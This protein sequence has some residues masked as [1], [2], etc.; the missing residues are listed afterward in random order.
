[1]KPS[2]RIDNSPHPLARAAWIRAA[3]QEADAIN[4]RYEFRRRFEL[5]EAIRARVV[6]TADSR[7]R[8]W[9]NGEWVSDGPARGYPGLSYYDTV[10]VELPAGNNTIEVEL[11]YWGVDTFQYLRASGGLIA[12]VLTDEGHQPLI[13]TDDMWMARPATQ[14]LRR[15]PRISCQQGFEEH[16]VAAARPAVWEPAVH[17]SACARELLPRETG[18]LG[19]RYRALENVVRREHVREISGGWSFSL[20]LMFSPFPRGI[21]LHGMA[22]AL[23]ARFTCDEA[24]QLRLYVLGN[25]AGVWV[26]G[27]VVTITSE[28]DLQRG[29]LELEAGS[30]RIGIALFAE[31]YQSTE[32]AVGWDGDGRIYWKP[33]GN[34]QSPWLTSGPLWA[35][36]RDT[37]C[38]IN[39]R[40]TSEDDV[41]FRAPFGG[42]FM[43]ADSALRD[44]SCRLAATDNDEIFRPLHN[45]ELHTADAYLA[46]RTDLC[47]EAADE[48]RET[49]CPGARLVYDLGEMTVGYLELEIEAEENA[50]VDIF[51][52]EHIQDGQIQYL[53]QNGSISYRNGLRYTASAGRQTFCSRQRRGFRYVL[54]VVRK[55]RI[56]LHRLGVHEATYQPP[57]TAAFACS[58][59]RLNR[60]YAVAQRTLLLCMEDTFTDCP[61]YEQAFWLGDAR[62]EALFARCAFGAADLIEHSLRLAARSLESLPMV[63]SQCPSGWDVIIPSFSFLW[64]IAVW[65]S[66]WES[67]YIGFLKELYP[68]L[69]LNLDNA[70]RHC[71]QQGLFRARAWNFFD[72]TGIDQEH[73]T[74]LHNSLLLAW[75]LEAGAKTA[76]KLGEDHDAERYWQQSAKL[77]QSIETLWDEDAGS[78]RDAI[79]P[80]GQPSPG[81]SQHTSFLALVQNLGPP[82]HRAAAVRN[83]LAPPDSLTQVGSPNA[84]FFL[85]ETLLREDF[86]QETLERLRAYWGAML[87]AGATTFWEM[88]HPPGS[89]FPT[90]SHCHG[91]SAAPV[92]LLPQLLFDVQRLEPGWRRVEIRPRPLG[93]DFARATLCTPHG[94]LKLEWQRRA[95]GEIETRVQAPSAITVN[96]KA[97]HE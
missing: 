40:T 22:G 52:F 89:T 75:A 78:Y 65:E 9:V 97:S 58:D 62:N 46:V 12:A 72:W 50:Q 43:P 47:L 49:L 88:I 79:L 34:G 37:N 83:C 68:A 21:N 95:D 73:E 4:A 54:L 25:V 11:L 10:V 70:L 5:R 35:G 18:P 74:V 57:Q 59:P 14:W 20:R 76:Q 67:G 3:C 28:Q 85:L 48:P 1:M 23:R 6:I 17:T 60:I 39:A 8:L 7:Y 66:Y 13:V 41:P 53:Y 61:T 63:A 51:C 30:H 86:A 32:L 45:K 27:N 33:A 16:Y 69:R 29:D 38:F 26:D 56:K 31:S 2:L 44:R 84:M 81:M 42:S 24:V 93:L 71:T 82:E 55:A 94:P 15:V 90:R 36:V 96:V 80:D 19:R 64:G 91:W 92:Y 77:A 87:D